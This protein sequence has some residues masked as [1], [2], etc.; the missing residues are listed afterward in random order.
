VLN[1]LGFLDGDWGLWDGGVY[2]G[3]LTLSQLVDWGDFGEK[4][5]VNKANEYI[6]DDNLC[7]NFSGVF[8]PTWYQVRPGWDFSALSSINYTISCKQAPNSAGGNSKTGNG[9]VGVSLDIDQTWNVALNYNIYYGP[10]DRG[11]AAFIKDRDNVALT[12]KRTF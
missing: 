9:S 10:Q 3:E 1:G 8:K 2:I 5:T 6:K 12:V 11:S 4:S 7:S